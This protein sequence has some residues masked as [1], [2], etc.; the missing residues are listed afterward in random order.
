MYKQEAFTKFTQLL[1]AISLDTLAICLRA[2]FG[3]TATAIV[4]ADEGVYEK[5]VLNKLEE[6]AATVPAYD[7]KAMAQPRFDATATKYTKAFG[8]EDPDIEVI[9]VKYTTSTATS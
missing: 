7:A 8:S 3:P 1:G 4:K 6:A 5:K 2:D 9:D